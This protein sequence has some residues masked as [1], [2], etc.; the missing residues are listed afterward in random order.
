ME[1]SYFTEREREILKV[2]LE[3]APHFGQ[4]T[5]GPLTRPVVVVHFVFG[6]MYFSVTTA[7][8]NVVED[9]GYFNDVI[10]TEVRQMF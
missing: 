5:K 3:E 7:K 1:K 4:F 9:P 2:R 8:R 6:E 10:Y